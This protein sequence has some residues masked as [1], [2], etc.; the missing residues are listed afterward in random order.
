MF[1]TRPKSGAL[2][3]TPRHG[4]RTGGRPRVKTVFIAGLVTLLAGAIGTAPRAL[5]TPPPMTGEFFVSNVTSGSETLTTDATCSRTDPSTIT[6]AATGTAVGPYPGTFTES[7]VVTVSTQA[8]GQFSNGV[9]LYKV[10]AIEAFFTVQ[11][12]F[13]DVA[14]TKRLVATDV[15]AACETF[16]GEVFPSTYPPVGV[17][18]HYRLLNPSSNGYGLAYDAIIRTADGVYR[19]RGISGLLLNDV[20]LSPAVVSPSKVLN[21]AFSS[22]DLTVLSN[23]GNATGGGRIETDDGPATF[24]FEARSLNG[25]KGRC[26]VVDQA[27]AVKVHCV[28][29]TEWLQISATE[30]WV[31]GRATVNGAATTYKIVARDIEEAG[32]GVDTFE[33]TTAAGYSISGTLASGNVQIHRR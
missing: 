13:G 22:T 7:G 31:S 32:S 3:A 28:D 10:S 8:A 12:T 23:V 11:S 15:Y 14:G 17:T 18:G 5:A 29:V 6:Y 27:A 30:V 24:G 1:S 26:E 4:R 9:P 33:L 16:A 2:D 19:D 21:E 25:L 20:D